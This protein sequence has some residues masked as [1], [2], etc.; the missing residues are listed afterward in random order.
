M[1]GHK[2]TNSDSKVKLALYKSSLKQEVEVLM[3]G[4]L[5]ENMGEIKTEREAIS[6]MRTTMKFQNKLCTDSNK[7]QGNKVTQVNG[8][9]DD[10]DKSI[11]IPSNADLLEASEK[12]N[13]LVVKYNECLHTLIYWLS[14]QVGKQE[15]GNTFNSEVIESIK[16]KFYNRISGFGVIEYLEERGKFMKKLKKH[17]GLIEFAQAIE[18]SDFLYADKLETGLRD[19]EH[20]YAEVYDMLLKNWETINEETGKKERSMY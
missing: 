7:M 12:V 4:K 18:T 13:T 15:T 1:N 2:S 9:N 3:N 6:M 5:M 16:D 19:L 8:S 11:I 17:D 14:L 20:Y 10:N